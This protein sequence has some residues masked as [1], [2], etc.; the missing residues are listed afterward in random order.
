[1]EKVAFNSYLP[2]EEYK[3]IKIEA[4]QLGINVKD[5]ISSILSNY[6]KTRKEETEASV[7]SGGAEDRKQSTKLN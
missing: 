4:V 7:S 6:V 3:I 2:D 1:M 5:H